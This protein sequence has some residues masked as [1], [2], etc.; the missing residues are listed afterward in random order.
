ME[1]GRRWK[2][3]KEGRKVE[4][5]GLMMGVESTIKEEQG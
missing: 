2:R 3:N 1:E 5:G 4:D